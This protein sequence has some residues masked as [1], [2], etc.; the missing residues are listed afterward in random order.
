MGDP[1]QKEK[2]DVFDSPEEL[3][4]E[5]ELESI[6]RL[7]IAAIDDRRQRLK[8]LPVSEAGGGDLTGLALSGGGIRAASFALGALQA[9]NQRGVIDRFDYLSTVSGGGYIG[10]AL[11][12]TM[13]QT[14]VFPFARPPAVDEG[15]PLPSDVSDTRAVSHLRNY[16]N[17]LIPFG[18][19]DLVTA[20]AIVLRG[21]VANLA[22]V[23]PFILLAAAVTIFLKPTRADLSMPTPL[24]G[25][26]NY[27]PVEN[28]GVTLL[29]VF[30]GMALFLLWALGRSAPW[31]QNAGE[32]RGPVP[33]AAS[34]F[35]AILAAAFFCELQPYL[36]LSMFDA[37]DTPVGKTTP[38]AISALW[39]WWIHRLA[40]VTAPVAMLVA[41]FRGRLGSF[42][43]QDGTGTTSR[44]IAVVV[45]KAAVWVAG[46]ALPLLIWVGYLNLSYWGIANH[47]GCGD[48]SYCSTP[49]EDT[50]R[51]CCDEGA[52]PCQRVE[53]RAARDCAPVAKLTPEEAQFIHAPTWLRHAVA[54]APLAQWPATAQ[55]YLAVGIALLLLSYPLTPNAN[56]L[57]RLY[58]DRLSKAFLFDP[59]ARTDE[60][61][62]VAKDRDLAPLTLKLSAIGDAGPYHLI[63]AALNVQGSDFANRRGRNADFFLF[64]KLRVGS[65]ATGYA[66][67]KALE[68]TATGLDLAT[69]MAISGAAA[70]SNMGAASIR[71]LTPTLALLNI[72]LGYWLANPRYATSAP[73][74]SLLPNMYLWSE[75]T[76]RLDEEYREVYLTDGGH[77][78]NLGVYE[79]LR[80]RCKLIVAI[81][82]EA[83]PNMVFPSLIEL[84]RYARIDLGVRIDLGWGAVQ[85]TTLQWMSWNARTRTDA[86]QPNSGPHVAVGRIDYGDGH[87]PGWLVYVK[88]SLSGDENDYVRD[89]ARRHPRFP[90]ETTGD[91][92]F[93]EEQ[94]EVYRA[95]GFHAMSGFLAGDDTQ[96]SASPTTLGTRDHFTATTILASDDRLR[97]VRKLLG[98]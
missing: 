94:F 55:V 65:Q 60:R 14:G 46:A 73:P 58:R 39:T 97:P 71:P 5:L 93:S 51:V 88:S 13:H 48:A 62:K 54:S 32:F 68:D 9:L 8:R 95:L 89:Y 81:D 1:S 56:S 90:H 52:G 34:I 30:T 80:R 59:S 4:F 96:V 18:P 17:Y 53:S 77:I 37:V 22:I 64:S 35:L 21:L 70:S 41:A 43:K 26:A 66:A 10:S 69:A 11:T 87:E 61:T 23:V 31:W 36:L 98:V 40:I 50:P 67:T 42:L 3:A 72:R 7:E 25:L 75:I 12:A 19:R 47:R 76:G 82:A 74:F 27:L 86:P 85:T 79:L 57:H 84:Q 78:E 16:S 38:D 2:E 29:L 15:K 28:F 20:V 45:T 33:F 63:N 6:R 24:F 91:Q 83:D 44:I 92:F 49:S